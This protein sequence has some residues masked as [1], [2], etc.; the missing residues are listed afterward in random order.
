MIPC[1][2]SHQ[3]EEYASGRLGPADQTAVEAHLGACDACREAIEA[4]NPPPL[5]TFVWPP[6]PV[7]AAR[8][9][10][11]QGETGP[12]SRAETHESSEPPTDPAIPPELQ[13][14]PRYRVDGV[15][16]IGGMGA[17][18]KAR[19]RLL[20][21]P[22]AL[23][24]IRQD[25]LD[26]PTQIERFAREAKLAAQL[27]HPNIITVYE[28]EKIGRSQVLVLEYLD[29]KDLAQ[30]V[31][32]RGPIPI[33][34]ACDWIRQAGVGLQYIHDRGF[35]HRDIK[36]SNLFLTSDGVV[37][38]LDLGIA[39]LTSAAE[40]N[41]ALTG[42][43]QILGTLDY[44]APE[45]WEASNAVDIRADIYSLG[46]T[47]YHLLTGQPPFGAANT[48]SS[49]MRQMW[50]HRHAPVP[51]LREK[52][53][54]VPGDLEAVVVK[55]LAKDPDARYPTPADVCGALASYASPNPLIGDSGIRPVPVVPPSP[56]GIMA[57][58]PRFA[59]R[60]GLAAIG[61]GI[62]LLALTALYWLAGGRDAAS[63]AA[64][65]EA[66]I[67][68]GT[69]IKVGVL[70][71]RTGTMA[72]S[73]RPVI[74]ATLFAIDEV[75]ERGGVLG[76]RVEAIV[77]DGQ[78][79]SA[80]FAARAETL[81]TRDNVSTIFG[82]WT[83]SSRKAVKPIVERHDRLLFYPL[84]NEGLEE[85]PNIFYLGASPNQ[86]II[87]AVRWLTTFLK[88][89]RLFLVGSDYV[90]PRAANAIIRDHAAALRAE[91]VGEEYMPLGSTQMEQI[92]AKIRASGADVVLNSINGDS[93]IAF[94]RELRAAG[95]V[96]SG[97]PT[98]SFS[99][100]EQELA[101]LGPKDVAG[102]Y[103][104]WSYFESLDDPRNHEFVRRF[105]AKFGSE[106]VVS[107]PMEA[108]YV[109][110]QLWAKAVET[111]GV[112]DVAEVRKAAAGQTVEAPEGRVLIDAATQR[113][114]KF[115]R[116]G[117]IATTGELVVVYSSDIPLLPIPYPETR[118]KAAWDSFL[119]DLHLGWGGQW[120]RPGT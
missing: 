10:A 72:I 40:A 18:Y 42:R 60:Y 62:A 88:K 66:A 54:D 37:K 97:V 100:G 98:L 25:L 61:A 119:T 120:A 69:P 89:R 58:R 29:G 83:S 82:C 49:V 41:V 23:K 30:V 8:P 21:R 5:P 38:I 36:P 74:D 47:L 65:S 32:S 19:H 106:R 2:S 56:T 12:A 64:P 39:F 73:E 95:V 92:A 102:D 115:V 105:R 45:Q 14:H 84:Q 55:M 57:G 93:N 63:P 11:P 27:S 101:S 20:D 114:V 86:Q 90:F 118:A 44:C 43:G 26:D 96:S 107:D 46:C 68:A 51:P 104:A 94:F 24:V 33:G 80:T 13:D 76:R 87:P 110:V 4:L 85:S 70:H 48:T 77:E 1:P 34:T 91:I 22:V 16:A 117:R 116:I 103:A 78:S 112:E 108:A 9:R 109:A 71:S 28:A 81:I 6:P 7:H 111:A 17:V 50:A 15:I 59:A 35:V 113:A 53:P 31:R 3:L 79:D 99:I 75:N 67:A 52:R